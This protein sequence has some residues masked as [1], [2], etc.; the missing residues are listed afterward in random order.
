MRVYLRPVP[1]SEKH[2]GAA[3]CA[4]PL[5]PLKGVWEGLIHNHNAVLVGDD[6]A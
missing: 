5:T 6:D 4:K 3:A 1:A 2:R